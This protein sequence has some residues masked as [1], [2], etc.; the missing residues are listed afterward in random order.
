MRVRL[1][2][3]AVA[4]LRREPLPRLCAARRGLWLVRKTEGELRD[5]AYRRLLWLLIAVVVVL[6]AVAGDSIAR[7]LRV[8]ERW[9]GHPDLLLLPVASALAVAGLALGTRA[10]RDG[11]PFAMAVGL[12][13]I[14]DRR[15]RSAPATTRISVLGRRGG[16]TSN[17]SALHRRGR[18]DLS[19]QGGEDRDWLLATTESQRIVRAVTE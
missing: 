19:R 3:S 6:L 10:R 14:D 11:V 5:W 4:R 16:G 2:H 7:N 18:L 17:R 9:R 1:G 12:V 8:F 15:G 13:A